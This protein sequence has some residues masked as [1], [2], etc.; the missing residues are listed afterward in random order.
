MKTG[1]LPCAFRAFSYRQIEKAV[2]ELNRTKKIISCNP[3][4]LSLPDHVG[5][6]IAL[7]RSS[8]PQ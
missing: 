2:D 1:L 4:I 8:S 5:C 7:N 6:F 3:S